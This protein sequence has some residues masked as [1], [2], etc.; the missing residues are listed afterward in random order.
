MT[1]P[2]SILFLN[3]DPRP[4]AGSNLSLL[5]LISGLD[6]RFHAVVAT[7]ANGEFASIL[8]AQQIEVVE[9][10]TNNWWYP[11][12]EHFFRA[13]AG[14]QTRIQYLTDL[15]QDRQLQLVHTNA[16][17]AFEGALAATRVGVP[18]IWNIRQIFGADMDI[19][20]FFPLSP[21]AL[22][23][24][25]ARLSDR[26]VPNSHPLI[27]TFPVNIPQEKFRVIA[28]GINFV[29]PPDKSLS[30]TVLLRRLSLSD[31][32]HIIISVG[33][34]SREKDLV[35]FIETARKLVRLDR[36]RPIHFVH[37]GSIGSAP[38]YEQL[39]NSLGELSQFV[40]FA[41]PTDTPLE[42]L[43][44]A[45]LLLFTSLFFEGLARVCLE[46]LSMALPVVATRCLGPEEYLLHGETALLAAV[47]DVD[48]LAEHVATLLDDPGYADH[49]AQNGYR[50]VTANYNAERV[51]T[52]WMQ[53]YDELL[54]VKRG[55][56]TSLAAVEVAI[57]LVSLC[58]QLGERM[59]QQENQLRTLERFHEQLYSPIRYGKKLIKK[60]NPFSRGG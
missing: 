8:R 58:G 12:Q 53:L 3:P 18:H 49:L 57:N 48:T 44:G 29:D 37:F 34:I 41:G 13:A 30:R 19:L 50:L 32:V 27:G 1:P 10:S 7:P 59:A 42:M 22:G 60:L 56:P 38:Y 6:A 11:D 36:R 47:G 45:D 55:Q 5:S 24:I 4:N 35:T 16:E 15:I 40:T 33:R 51:C 39:Q 25:M 43:R 54:T 28:S 31:D 23:D 52:Q 2:I 26:I 14:F 21:Q 46:A 9:Y 20:R 17:Y